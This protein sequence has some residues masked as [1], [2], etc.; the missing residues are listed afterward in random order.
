MSFS[1]IVLCLFVPSPVGGSPGRAC[2]YCL[3]VEEGVQIAGDVCGCIPSFAFGLELPGHSGGCGR[4]V[5]R[6]T[7][8]PLD[9]VPYQK[10]FSFIL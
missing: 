8:P 9:Y 7:R 3:W 4:V 2:L 6:A 10:P 5:D 1:C